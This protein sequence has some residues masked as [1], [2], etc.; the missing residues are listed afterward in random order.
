M[1]CGPACLQMIAKHYG[2]KYSLSYLRDKSYVTKNGVSLLGIADTA[3]I[4]GFKT[5]T[6]QLSLKDLTNNAHLPCI[7]YW[8]QNHFVVLYDVVNKDNDYIFKVADPAHGLLAFDNLEFKKNWLVGNDEVGFVLFLNPPDYSLHDIKYEEKKTNSFKLLYTYL[9]PFKRDFFNFFVC[10]LTG[11][12]L[13]LILPFL[14]QILID[15]GVST[16]DLSISFIILLAQLFLFLGST[17]SDV[18][19]NQVLLVTGTK[20]GATIMSDFLKKLMNIPL[21]FFDTKLMGDFNQRIQDQERIE[22]F[23]TS[24][25]L[26]TFFS[27]INFLV[28]FIVLGF[29]DVKILIVYLIITSISMV[30]MLHFLKGRK[31]LDYVRFQ[32]KAESQDSTFEIL[33]GIQEIKLN[34]FVSAK[35]SQWERIQISLFRINQ[36]ILTLD[37]YQIVGYN[38]INQLKNI[39]VMYLAVQGVIKNEL[40]LGGMISITYIMGQMNGPLTQLVTFFRSYQDAKISLDR[41]DEIHREEDEEKV[42]QSGILIES[43]KSE[44]INITN[45]SFQYAGPRSPKVI[46]NLNINIPKGKITAI[47]GSSGSGKSTLLKLLLKFYNNYEGS[48]SAEGIDLLNLSAKQWRSNCGAVMQDGYIFSDTIENNIA[49]GNEPID[50]F[51]LTEATRIS[52]LTDFIESLP[53]GFNTKIGSAGNGLSGGQKQRILIARA[54]YKNPGYLFFDEATSSLDA[55]NEKM[56]VDNLN[57]YLIGRTAVIIAHRLSTVKNADQII[58]LHEGKIV[59]AGNHDNLVNVKGYYFNLIKNQLEL[60]S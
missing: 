14:T 38:V 56:I 8:N 37:Q 35:T 1:D 3:K 10:L 23:L 16:R 27:L 43:N 30:W 9:R 25:G 5:L 18:I 46:D 45:L 32:H 13:T 54:I 7:L 24:Q 47:V 51:R 50:V 4:I 49:T 58:V 34:D 20:I 57:N 44:G 17:L 2:K 52:N 29:Y 6:A 12:I 33:N 40:T 21:S 42:E 15:Q 41:L 55:V 53:L 60:G 36:K 48:I 39:I 59:E 31:I 28:L 11:S 22:I 26:L 19:R